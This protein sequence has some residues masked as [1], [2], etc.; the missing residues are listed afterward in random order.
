MLLYNIESIA[1]K[2]EID[3]YGVTSHIKHMG[4][5]G[6][7]REHILR[8]YLKQ[9]LPQKFA[10]GSGVITD[11]NGAQSKQQDFIIYDA[12]NSPA[13]LKVDSS[14]TVLPIESVYATIE[15]KS[16]LTKKKIKESLDNF[17]SVRNL[18]LSPYY[19]SQTPNGCYNLRCGYIFSYTSNMSLDT[20]ARHV[21][22]LCMDLPIEKQPTIICVLDKGLIVHVKKDNPLN[23]SVSPEVNTV[24]ALIKNKTEHN[25]Y[26][27]YLLLYRYLQSAKLLP[28]DLWTYGASLVNYTTVSFPEGV[29]PENLALPIGEASVPLNDLMIIQTAHRLQ[30]K[31][32]SDEMD[33]TV[34]RELGLSTEQG[35][36]LLKRADEMMQK[37]DGQFSIISD[38]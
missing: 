31:D 29:L 2:M 38:S 5:C 24:W 19:D 33:E 13:F 34:L 9:L 20:L 4:L 26:L 27:F 16:S 37:Y 18:T 28:P 36:Q 8:E 3:Y 35:R 15:V 1:K 32:G 17:V 30:K 10:V 6:S 25:L 7:A 14:S 11:A 22:E 21:T 12:F 23:V